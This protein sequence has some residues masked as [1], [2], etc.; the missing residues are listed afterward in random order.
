MARLVSDIGA[1]HR[2]QTSHARKA[3]L[4]REMAAAIT[5]GAANRIAGFPK[6][7]PRG[8]TPARSRLSRAQKR[9]ET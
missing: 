2:K 4:Y 3:V 5:M 8:H 7:I 1:E 9:L 6:Y